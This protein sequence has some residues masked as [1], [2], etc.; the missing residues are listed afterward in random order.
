MGSITG[1]VSGVVGGTVDEPTT[2]LS[3]LENLFNQGDN[4]GEAGLLSGLASLVNMNSIDGKRKLKSL[5]PDLL[6]KLAARLAA[7][8]G[9]LGKGRIGSGIIS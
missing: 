4:V 5:L 7:I 8:K 9:R 1:S 6:R 3:G 2:L